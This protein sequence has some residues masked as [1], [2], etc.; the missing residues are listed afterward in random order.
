MSLVDLNSNSLETTSNVIKHLNPEVYCRNILEPLA[1]KCEKFD[2][3]SINYLLHCLPGD[4]S[5]KSIAFLHLSATMNKG[6]VLFGSTI[7]GKETTQNMPAKKL[8]AFY[9][10]K[11]IFS[12]VNDDLASLDRA[13]TEYFS[14]VKIEVVGCVA[15]FSGVKR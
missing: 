14:D 1:L 4:L 7:L 3:V 13:L 5:E 15:I 11:G 8:M 10:K 12:N 6:G 9:N 2:S